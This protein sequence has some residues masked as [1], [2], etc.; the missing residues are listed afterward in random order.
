MSYS[1]NGLK[2]KSRFTEY[3]CIETFNPLCNNDLGLEQDSIGNNP[4]CSLKRRNHIK[5]KKRY[6]KTITATIT[7]TTTTTTTKNTLT[8]DKRQMTI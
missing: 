3:F 8:I 4:V 1:Q 6:D 7:T 2:Q 5:R